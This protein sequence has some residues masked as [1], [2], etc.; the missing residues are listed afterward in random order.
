VL[1]RRQRI[2]QKALEILLN[3]TGEFST[4]M[5][6]WEGPADYYKIWS[7]NALIGFFKIKPS[8]NYDN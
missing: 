8:T 2:F 4:K 6:G 5:I 1:A 3:D 7:A